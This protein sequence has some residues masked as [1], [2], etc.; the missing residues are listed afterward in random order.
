MECPKMSLDLTL[1]DLDRSNSRK[2]VET[3]FQWWYPLIMKRGVR[4]QRHLVMKCGEM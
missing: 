3:C 1:S 4:A 2:P